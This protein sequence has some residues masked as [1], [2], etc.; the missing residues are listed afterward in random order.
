[1]NFKNRMNWLLVAVAT[2]V[3]LIPA[4]FHLT[5]FNAPETDLSGNVLLDDK[6]LN[7]FMDQQNNYLENYFNSVYKSQKSQI[8][9]K[10]S[11]GSISREE[12]D[13]ELESIQDNLNVTIK[14]LNS[15]TDFRKDIFS[16]NDTNKSILTH[17]KS[18]K[19]VNIDLKTEFRETLNGS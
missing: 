11:S 7:H 17:F 9:R 14:T 2:L 16:G 4:F 19:N 18:L 6:S 8:E 10:Y 3:I 1:M 15:L 5:G 13:K 12:R